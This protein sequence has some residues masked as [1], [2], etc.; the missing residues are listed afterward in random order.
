MLQTLERPSH[1]HTL[2]PNYLLV[3]SITSV[4]SFFVRCL[5]ASFSFFQSFI[6]SLLSL[7]LL[8]SCLL[9]PCVPPYCLLP[10][11]LPLRLCL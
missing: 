1:T 11:L 7:C 2:L 8:L 10:C 3:V 9:A 4:P 5:I 6:L